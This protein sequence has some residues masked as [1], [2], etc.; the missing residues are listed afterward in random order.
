MQ[1]SA[2]YFADTAWQIW[3]EISEIWNCIVDVCLRCFSGTFKNI[4]WLTGQH[5]IEDTAEA[6]DITFGVAFF[7]TQ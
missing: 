2:N 6:V 4:G 7:T 1:H 5:L 3:A